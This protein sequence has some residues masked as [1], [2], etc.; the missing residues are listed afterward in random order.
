[1]EKEG[2]NKI[3]ITKR[4]MRGITGMEWGK[5]SFERII[6]VHSEEKKIVVI[7]GLPIPYYA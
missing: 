7:N 5:G 1:L 2:E 3:K 4:R 6:I